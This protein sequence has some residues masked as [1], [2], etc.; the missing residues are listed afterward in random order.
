MDS[1]KEGPC[2]EGARYHP[3]VSVH[4]EEDST[5]I[6]L[7][8]GGARGAYQAGALQALLEICAEAGIPRPFGILSG[9][10]AGAINTTYLASRMDSPVEGARDL[11]EFWRRLRTDR[12]FRTDSASILSIGMRWL[13]DL[14]LGG[15]HQTTGVRS[16]VDTTPLSDLLETA[17][18]YRRLAEN[19]R[20]G[21]LGALAITA[22]DYASSE[23]VTF[24]QTRQPFHGWIRPRRRGI[25]A[26]IRKEHVI[27][28]AAI[29]IFFPAVRVDGAYYGDGGLRNLT[30]LA[31][32]LRL[33]ARRLIVIGV[34]RAAPPGSESFPDV[35]PSVARIASVLLNSIFL[36][37]VEVDLERLNDTNALIEAHGRAARPEF[38]PV[39]ALYLQ[40]SAD[41]PRI[42]MDAIASLPAM[43]RYMIRGLGTEDEAAELLSYLLFEPPYLDQLVQLGYDDTRRR[44]SEIADFLVPGAGDARVAAAGRS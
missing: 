13:W 41:P 24:V 14:A 6:V 20:S 28:S 26:D 15:V 27:G 11:A 38:R 7:T 1:K 35:R 29:P 3:G 30:P 31:P 2:R 4:H 19:A 39:K 40:P 12:V 42:A 9:M 25:P 8:G 32:A 10:S 36:D 43:I 21:A 18:D 44:S 5:G 17:I 23:C 34:R 16:L 22:M 37:A 33:G